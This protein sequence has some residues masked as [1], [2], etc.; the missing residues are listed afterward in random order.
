MKNAIFAL[1]ILTVLLYSCKE[2]NVINTPELANTQACQD[3]LTA[4]NIF[5]DVDHIVEGAFLDNGI[6]KSYPKFTIMNNDASNIDTLIINF[7]ANE[8]IYPYPGGKLRKG[9]INV[10]YTGKY[11]DSLAVIT[12]TFDNYY[13]NYNLIQGEMT[14]TNQGRKNNGNICFTIEVNDASISTPN[15]TINWE[16]DIVKEWTSGED[17]YLDLSDD[18]YKI[19]GSAS[20]NGVNGNDFTMTIIDTLNVALSCFPFCV[21]KS[22]TSKITPDGYANR[23]VNYGESLCD[24]NIDVIINE[25]NYPIVI[26]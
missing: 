14:V 6:N 26:N 10:T 20:G 12:T 2:Q 17:T 13:V 1:G 22:G 24:C 5:N 7:G 23:I 15:G 4:E 8:I 16:S 11:R 18:E 21:I 19:T 3:H 25:D 9:K